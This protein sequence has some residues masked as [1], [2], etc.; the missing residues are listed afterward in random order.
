MG[1]NAANGNMPY[2]LWYLSQSHVGLL[3]ETLI[4]FASNDTLYEVLWAFGK[5]F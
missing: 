3:Q 1:S 4:N 5:I 2:D